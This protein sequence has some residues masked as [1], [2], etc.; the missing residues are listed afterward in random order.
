[1][2]TFSALRALH[3]LIGEA[4]NDIERIFLSGQPFGRPPTG[5]GSAHPRTS[6]GEGLNR[7]PL[8]FPSLDKPYDPVSPAEALLSHPTVV[9]AT[10]L[11]VSATGQL[12]ATVQRP[13]LTICD[14]TMGVSDAF[15]FQCIE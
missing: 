3:T 7:A 9:R 6:E 12:A 4:L 11:I 14:A 1:M 2:A 5:S 13:F 15:H 10:K 8:D